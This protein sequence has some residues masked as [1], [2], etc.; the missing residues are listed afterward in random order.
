MF[1]LPR[2]FS[3]FLA[4]I[5]YFVIQGFIV[6]EDFVKPANVPAERGKRLAKTYCG[7]C[8]QVP[9]PSDLN[10]ESWRDYVLPRMRKL[11]QLDT[12]E[13]NDGIYKP[14]FLTEMKKRGII[15]DFSG[16]SAADWKRIEDYYLDRAG[17]KNSQ[18]IPL[19]VDVNP[20]IFKEE[21][22]DLYTSPPSTSLIRLHGN[23]IWWGDVHSRSL[24]L[25]NTKFDILYSWQNPSEAPVDIQDF[26]SGKIITY[27]GSFSPSDHSAGVICFI[28][29]SQSYNQEILITGLNRP[30]HSTVS[31]INQDGKSDIIVAEFG[32]WLGQLSY[33]RNRGETTFEKV[34]L[35]KSAGCISSAVHDLNEDG[36]PDILALF[37]QGDEHISVF[38]QQKDGSF[39]EERLITFPPGYG[40]SG[41][42]ITDYNKDDLPD[43]LYYN[44]DLAD[45]PI[46]SKPYQGIRIFENT[47]N[48][49]FAEKIFLP[50]SGVYGV[51]WKDFD[52]D[53]DMDMIC[54]SFFPN[55][56]TPKIP[57]LV[58]YKNQSGHFTPEKL[59]AEM[60]GRWLVIDSGDLDNDGDQDI[61]AGNLIMEL[62]GHE[63]E[64][65]S[66]IQNGLPFVILKNQ[67]RVSK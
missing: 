12:F 27:M 62:P 28:D 54:N 57:G 5:G 37:A 17:I 24:H 58:F 25:L 7:V 59:P 48:Q 56:T 32:K 31:D 38:Y 22:P 41:F 18:K 21:F 49:K 16:I 14:E 44:G 64:T 26:Q 40:S 50:L 11:M 9:E 47:G 4:L 55:N 60:S 66:W 65:A 13:E 67:T 51:L 30:V 29:T 20:S 1:A 43:I 35:S 61:L 19:E 39:Y 23:H 46:V 2:Q 10:V 3:G 42:K 63:K 6:T 36:R 53:G 8:H 52:L 34:I 45:F 33:F 15:R